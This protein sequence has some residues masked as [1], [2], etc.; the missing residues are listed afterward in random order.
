MEWNTSKNFEIMEQIKRNEHTDKWIIQYRNDKN[1]KHLCMLNICLIQ[2]TWIIEIRL[3]LYIFLYFV[4]S[5]KT[6]KA[7]SVLKFIEVN[8]QF[9]HI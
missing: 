7:L 5:G 8:F 2:V 3:K 6:R 4:W 9:I 1:N